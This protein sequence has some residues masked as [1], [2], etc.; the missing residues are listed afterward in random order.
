MSPDP[1]R[2]NMADEGVRHAILRRETTTETS[3]SRRTSDRPHLCV[4][5]LRPTVLNANPRGTTHAPFGHGIGGIGR[6]V[7][8]KQVIRSDTRR[9]IT[10]M[11][12]PLPLW[13]RPIDQFPTHAMGASMSFEL[14]VS[15]A[16]A[17]T[18]PVPMPIRGRGHL[19]PKPLR[20]RSP[21]AMELPHTD[22]GTE[23]L[24][25]FA[26]S[27]GSRP[28]GRPADLACRVNTSHRDLLDRSW[29]LGNTGA[30]PS[31]L[32]SRFSINAPR[33]LVGISRRFLRHHVIGT[34]C[35][36]PL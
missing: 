28:H 25:W 16:S 29:W 12:N 17:V 21:R 27:V 13:D 23:P 10:S 19:L 26:S 33:L 5:Q 1:V 30:T 20:Q 14:A 3:W 35:F 15:I 9:R 2:A 34:L 11:E 18:H 31:C 24:P 22:H 32:C 8:K 4:R 7:T 6:M 36:G